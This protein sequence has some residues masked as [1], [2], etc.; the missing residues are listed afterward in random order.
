[1]TIGLYELNALFLQESPSL[2]QPC[3]P[4]SSLSD[5]LHKAQQ[6]QV[7][8]LESQGLK[9]TARP[10]RLRGRR[11]CTDCVGHTICLQLVLEVAEKSELEFYDV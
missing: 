6:D 5:L 2:G 3:Q 1:M 8:L 7:Q 4:I 9:L 11:G 10:L